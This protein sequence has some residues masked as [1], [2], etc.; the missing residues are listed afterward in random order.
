MRPSPLQAA[1]LLGGLAVAFGAF[2]THALEGVIESRRLITFE[3][4]VRYQ[5]FHALALLALAALPRGTHRAAPFFLFGSLVFSGSLYGL[6]FTGAGWLGAVAPIGGVSM[7]SGWA[8]LL[9]TAAPR[10]PQD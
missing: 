4:A 7:I 5:M 9:F 2:G 8:V 3:T 10:R 6:V 1:A